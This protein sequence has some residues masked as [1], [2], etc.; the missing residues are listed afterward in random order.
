MLTTDYQICLKVDANVDEAASQ[1]RRVSS[2]WTRNFRGETNQKGDE[3]CVEFGE[4]FVNFVVCSATPREIVWRVTDCNLHWL[5]DRKEW[6][7]TQ[8]VWLLESDGT[9]TTITMT[10][11]GLKKDCECYDMCERGWNFYVGESLRKLILENI[12]R[13]DMEH[14]SRYQEAE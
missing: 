2:W 5:Q 12:G 6:Q 11:V 3:F 1:I 10:H 9:K 4:T 8:V 7:G 13:P 14:A